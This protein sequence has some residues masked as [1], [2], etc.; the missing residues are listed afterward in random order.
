MALVAFLCSKGSL[1]KQFKWLK[2]TSLSGIFGSPSIFFFIFAQQTFRS[3]LICPKQ[4]NWTEVYMRMS[5][6]LINLGTFEAITHQSLAAGTYSNYFRRFRR[7]LR[8]LRNFRYH[9]LY[10][11]S[12]IESFPVRNLIGTIVFRQIELR[13]ILIVF[14]TLFWVQFAGLRPASDHKIQPVNEAL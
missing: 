6:C 1:S 9:L 11:S 13:I 14:R 8:K 10:G 2:R 3:N 4:P 5:N 12:S 7:T